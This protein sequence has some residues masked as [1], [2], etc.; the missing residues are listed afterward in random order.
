MNKIYLYILLFFGLLSTAQTLTNNGEQFPKF[1]SCE[2]LQ[3]KA[4][5]DCFYNNVQEYVYFKIIIN[6]FLHIIIKTIF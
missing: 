2:A 4:L 5:E 3:A 1:K 6:V